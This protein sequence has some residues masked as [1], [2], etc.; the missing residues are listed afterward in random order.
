MKYDV[1]IAFSSKAVVYLI[2]TDGPAQVDM[3]IYPFMFLVLK[4]PCGQ[5][6]I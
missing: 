1:D 6:L 4:K 5:Q 3:C 2:S